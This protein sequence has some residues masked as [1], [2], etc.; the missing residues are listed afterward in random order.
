MTARTEPTR[1]PTSGLP[2]SPL[3]WAVAAADTAVAVTTFV[4]ARLRGNRLFH[5]VGRV[6]DGTLSVFGTPDNYYRTPLLDRTQVHEVIVRL[7]KATSTPDG[8]P[9]VL[10]LAVRLGNPPG[11]TAGPFD[12]LLATTSPEPVLRRLLFVPRR[13]FAVAYGSLLPYRVGGRL[14]LLGALPDGRSR[15]RNASLDDAAALVR[16]P[17]LGFYLAEA[18]TFSDWRPF[19]KLTLRLRDPDRDEDPNGDNLCFDPVRN[20]LSTLYPA[21]L[22]NALRSP[23]YEG[24]QHGRGAPCAPDLTAYP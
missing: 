18:A 24:S 22:F 12:L 6:F 7:S 11:P 15:G 16:D 17:G 20:S 9:D 13:Q 1:P 3:R 23:A 8:W 21:G 19:A 10:G 4:G 14:R 5:P 2:I